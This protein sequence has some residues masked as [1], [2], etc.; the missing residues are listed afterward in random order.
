MCVARP[1]APAPAQPTPETAAERSVIWHRWIGCGYHPDAVTTDRC[2][3]CPIGHTGTLDGFR[4]VSAAPG[5][6]GDVNLADG[7]EVS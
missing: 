1:A 4:A 3:R 7:S 5:V 6:S 2:K